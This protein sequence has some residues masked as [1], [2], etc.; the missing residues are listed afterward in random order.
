MENYGVYEIHYNFEVIYMFF[1]GINI[2]F[3]Y[4]VFCCDRFREP[5]IDLH[6]PYKIQVWERSNSGFTIERHMKIQILS[7]RGKTKQN[8]TIEVR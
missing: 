4:L 6:V 5:R 7:K 3:E 8:K 2:A 1:W